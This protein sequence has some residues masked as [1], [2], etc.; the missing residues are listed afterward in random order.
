MCA[1]QYIPYTMIAI[2]GMCNYSFVIC[3]IYIDSLH[4]ELECRHRQSK[5]QLMC[6]F[7]IA[8]TIT[9]NFAYFSVNFMIHVN[10]LIYYNYTDHFT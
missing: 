9:I 5:E 4:S 3:H 8:I 6:T 10:S 2:H 7:T 1:L